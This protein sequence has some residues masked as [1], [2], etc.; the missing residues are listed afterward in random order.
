[1]STAPDQTPIPRHAPMPHRKIIRSWLAPIV[2]RSTPLALALI[3]IDLCLF[4]A[5]LTATVWVSNLLAKIVL[6]MVTGFIIGRLFILGHDACHQSLTEHRRLNAWLGRLVFLPS[7]TPYSLWAVGHNVV[8]HG[9]TNLRAFDFV[10]QPHSLEEFNALPR[11]RQR[12]EKCYRS[13]WAPWLYYMVDMWWK[14]MYFPSRKQMPTRRTEFMADGALVTTAAAVW[15]GALAWVAYHGDQS[16]W[17]LLVT[18]FIVPVLF[19]KAMIGFV[20]YVHHTHTE[21]AWYED[22]VAW[23]A[24]QPFVST[25]VHL[26]FGAGIGA[27][28]HH[29]MEHT[30]H[31]VDMSVPL[32]RLKKAQKMLETMLPG[33]IVIQ[34][35]SW[36]W[37]FDT[38][39]RCKLYDY[40]RLCWTDFKGRP[41]STPLKM[42]EAA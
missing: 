24:A 42:A 14:R 31:H 11:W 39:R 7:L 1:M 32:Y 2:K 12:L 10:W 29:I 40:K 36:R 20:V 37:Y 30:A 16:F 13:G 9:Y 41:T 33:R 5:A 3:A 17:T 22:K 28:L 8:H 34:R 35:F 26:T 19:W 27:A 6:G 18:A 23:A 21:V 38:A 15:I 25:T 4:G